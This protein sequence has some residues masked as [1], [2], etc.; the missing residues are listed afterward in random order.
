[1]T[2][3]GRRMYLDRLFQRLTG[4]KHLR[5]INTV[6]NAVEVLLNGV[7]MELAEIG[8]SASG[9]VSD[10]MERTQ[11]ARISLGHVAEYCGVTEGDLAFL[12]KFVTNG[13]PKPYARART[14]DL[15]CANIIEWEDGPD[16]GW[17]A[18][19]EVTGYRE[20]VGRWY[21]SRHADRRE[22]AM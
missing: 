11:L 20:L 16:G 12:I 4:G 22:E 10:L 7:A 13:N 17:N 6:P 14:L 1:M 5:E 8:G 2:P 3:M 21:E 18:V 19:G 9:D 15:L